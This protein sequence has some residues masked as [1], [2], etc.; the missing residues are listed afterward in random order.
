MFQH[1][2]TSVMEVNKDRHALERMCRK[3]E[4]IFPKE[5][6][7]RI[8]KHLLSGEVNLI[9]YFDKRA[10]PHNKAHICGQSS[11]YQQGAHHG[12]VIGRQLFGSLCMSTQ[13]SCTIRFLHVCSGIF[14]PARE[15]A[16]ALSPLFKILARHVKHGCNQAKTNP[17]RFIQTAHGA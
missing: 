12:L 10:H 6:K 9:L 17:E 2:C 11:F 14:V 1:N 8:R 16:R 4:T 3:I 13:E 5:V 7:T 15:S